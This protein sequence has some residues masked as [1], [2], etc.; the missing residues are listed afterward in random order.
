MRLSHKKIL[1]TGATSGIGKAS[2]EACLN[3]GAFVFFTGRDAKKVRD[4]QKHWGKQTI[5]L[6]SDASDWKA[7]SVLVQSITQHTPTLDAI[8]LNAGDVTHAPLTEWDS[9]SFDRVFNTNV[10]A[11]FFL[12]QSALPLLSKN[13]TV[14]LC[15]STSIHIGLAQSSVYAASKAALRSLVKTLSGELLQRNIR[16]NLL[17]PGP[18][19]TDAFD[20]LGLQDEQK[21]L[22]IDEIKNLVPLGRLAKPEELAQAVVFLASDESRFMLG[23]EILMDGG[24]ANL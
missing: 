15:G 2:V 1:I 14:I 12:I 5:G 16:F 11:P 10:K 21:Q 17:S 13:S 24:V 18:T 9:I 6:V 22:M 7:Q 3:E 20:K 19:Y 8:Y 4:L 23:T